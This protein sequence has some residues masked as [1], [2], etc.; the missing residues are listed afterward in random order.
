MQ[1]AIEGRNLQAHAFQELSESPVEKLQVGLDQMTLDSEIEQRLQ[2]LKVTQ[3][4]MALRKAETLVV[5]QFATAFV[6]RA[7]VSLLRGKLSGGVYE[8]VLQFCLGAREQPCE[9]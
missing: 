9:E 8:L 3:T 5:K 4:R 1:A 6:I 7:E 2:R